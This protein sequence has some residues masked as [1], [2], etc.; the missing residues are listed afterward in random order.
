MFI[1]KKNIFIFLV[2]IIFLTLILVKDA[3]LN[4]AIFSLVG[5]DDMLGKKLVKRLRFSLHDEQILSG[6]N[7]KY[8]LKDNSG[9]AW[10]FKTY[11][12]AQG[13]KKDIAFSKLAQVCGINSSRCFEATLPVNKK[14]IYGSLQRMVPGLRELEECEELDYTRAQQLLNAHIFKWLCGG[15]EID[16]LIS[17]DKVFLFDIG[18][19]LEE[20]SL[21]LIFSDI[22]MPFIKN[23]IFPEK[24]YFDGFI[25]GNYI[26]RLNNQTINRILS[27]VFYFNPGQGALFFNRRNNAVSA[28]SEFYKEYINEKLTKRP[29]NIPIQFYF[30]IINNIIFSISGKI[31]E[32]NAAPIPGSPQKNLDIITS[33]RARDFASAIK[34]FDRPTLCDND[35]Y[36]KDRDRRLFLENLSRL[37][38][39]DADLYDKLCIIIYMT[40]FKSYIPGFV[41]PMMRFTFHP[42]ELDGIFLEA[43]LRISGIEG[44]NQPDYTRGQFSNNFIEALDH[45]RDR[46]PEGAIRILSGSNDFL[47]LLLLGR[48]YETGN[49]FCRFYKG[50]QLDKAKE[51]YIRALEKN[52][53]SLVCLINLFQIY[54]LENDLENV[55][56]MLKKMLVVAPWIENYWGINSRLI[57]TALKEPKGAAIGKIRLMSLSKEDCCVLG[58]F[59]F[60]KNDSIKAKAYLD[61]AKNKGFDNR[62]LAELYEKIN[63][64]DNR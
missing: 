20:D 14:F 29:E 1:K 62:L 43:N 27:P 55:A 24:V 41:P 57:D 61:L 32:I 45:I 15:D 37:Q 54:L 63:K 52:N 5:L 17:N 22:F 36:L 39:L 13:V 25:F 56:K 47:S 28:Y 59:Y 2:C 38:Y 53:N 4:Q 23:K 16:I 58:L 51:V 10:L 11:D 49:K 44:E 30:R 26:Q 9:K 64:L 40:Q 42:D 7:E 3:I 35:I 19:V 12:D 31:K 6:G 46:D 34:S 48:I 18:E 21:D 60:L 50:C 8:V 33:K